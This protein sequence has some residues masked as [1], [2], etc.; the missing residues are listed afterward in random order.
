[1]TDRVRRALVGAATARTTLEALSARPPGGSDRWQRVNF[2]GRD[3]SLLAGP[4]LALSVVSSGPSA[5]AAL[6]SGLVGAYDDAVGDRDGVKGF[7]GHLA[8]LASG[9]LTAGGVKLLGLSVVGAAAARLIRPVRLVDVLVGGAVVAGSANLVNLL[10]LRPG[11]ALKIGLI[12][13]LVLDEPRIAGSCAALLPR[14][15]RESAMLGDAGAN[16]LGAGLGVAAVCRLPSRGQQLTLLAGLA[17][18]TAASERVS[19]SAVIERTPPLRYV[20]RLGRQ[21]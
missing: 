1:M 15:L 14:D 3:V 20:D 8:A 19:F 9:R 16:A 7:R 5:V 12:T 17:A 2:R 6:G 10:D 18:L 11:R 13:A 21:P 4:A